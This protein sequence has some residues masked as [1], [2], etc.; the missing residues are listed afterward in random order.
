MPRYE[1]LDGVGHWLQLEAPDK[2]NE[3]L[4]GFLSG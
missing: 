4:V 1:R 2:L 3:L